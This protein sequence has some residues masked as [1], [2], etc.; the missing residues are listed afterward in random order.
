MTYEIKLSEAEHI[1]EYDT[2]SMCFTITIPE[3]VLRKQH[4]TVKDVIL[5][6]EKV[7]ISPETSTLN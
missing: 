3:R 6:C 5:V 1:V 4:A 2:V 7:D